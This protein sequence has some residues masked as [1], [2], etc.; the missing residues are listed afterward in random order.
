MAPSDPEEFLRYDMARLGGVERPRVFAWRSQELQPDLV[1]DAGNIA[2]LGQ[3]WY[4]RRPDFVSEA[5]DHLRSELGLD[6]DTWWRQKQFLIEYG[7]SLYDSSDR[8]AWILAVGARKAFGRRLRDYDVRAQHDAR[9]VGHS[10]AL[11]ALRSS[12]IGLNR[13][14]LNV[15]GFLPIHPLV[16]GKPISFQRVSII[17][18]VGAAPRSLLAME[19][20][21][22]TISGDPEETRLAARGF[23]PAVE[24]Y[25]GV[26]DVHRSPL[27]NFCKLDEFGL[28]QWRSI[29]LH[30]HIGYIGDMRASFYDPEYYLRSDMLNHTVLEKLVTRGAYESF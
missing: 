26:D 12:S 10:V 25:R 16:P 6:R 7:C 14:P 27:I 9:L 23:T 13:L 30:P 24:L 3:S 1:V 2:W 22:V 8:P 21:L 18:T 28:V 17:R 15:R 20:R 29:S 19:D 11:A 4:F 5:L